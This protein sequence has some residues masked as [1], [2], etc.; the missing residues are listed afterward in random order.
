[1]KLKKIARN[2]RKFAVLGSE[3][4]QKVS[5]LTNK[6]TYRHKNSE[7]W[8]M[9]GGA[10]WRA[11]HFLGEANPHPRGSATEQLSLKHFEIFCT[12]NSEDHMFPNHGKS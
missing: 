12:K 6:D 11:R 8:K 7:V 5:N 9:L 2:A 4:L 1:M 3:I 10:T